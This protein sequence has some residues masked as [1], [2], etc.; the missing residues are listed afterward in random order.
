VT[1][2][3][4]YFHFI[5]DNFT[6]S[7][8]EGG[9]AAYDSN[10]NLKALKCF[11][12]MAG[13]THH[14]SD[15]FRSTGSVGYVDLENEASQGPAAYHK[16]YYAS[17]NLVYQI[18]KRLSVGLEALYGKKEV[19]NGDKGDVVRVQLGMTMALFE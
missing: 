9:D 14:W 2:G 4:G 3:A 6:Y 16:T 18:R 17:A 19:N 7:G 12:A 13:Y 15:S 11:S 10:G 8:F 1:Y 5:N